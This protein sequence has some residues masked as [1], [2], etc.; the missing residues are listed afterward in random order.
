MMF[1]KFY[2]VINDYRKIGVGSV[3]IWERLLLD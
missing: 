3:T 2:D 1:G